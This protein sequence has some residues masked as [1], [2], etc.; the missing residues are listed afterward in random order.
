MDS[1]TAATLGKYEIVSELG[2]GGMGVV[3]RARDPIIGRFVAVKTLTS[4]LLSSPESLKR[5]YREAQAA[6]KLQHPNIVTI[7]DLGETAG[8]P[9]IA[10]EFVEGES[11]REAIVRQDP[12]PLPQKLK[13]IKQFC[14]GLG[15]AHRHGLVHR[16]VKPANILIRK[17]G[18]VKV[19]DFGIVHVE[20]TTITKSG[21]FMGTVYY[22][23][24]EQIN[25]ANVD[26]RSD[27]F[28]VG[29]VIYEFLAYLRPFDSSTMAGVINLI[30]NR[31][32]VP[33]GELVPGIPPALEG[34]VNRC[35]Q[36]DPENR[37]QSLEDLVFELDPLASALQHDRA[38]ELVSQAPELIARR[39]LAQARE[40]LHDALMLESNHPV[41]KNLLSHVDS[42][43][44]RL[45][46][47]TRLGAFVNEGWT[48]LERREYE[49]AVKSFEEAVKVD[50]QDAQAQVLLADAREKLAQANEVHQALA[51]AKTAYRG[52]DLTRAEVTLHHVLE[53]DATN[54][55]AQ[56]ILDRIRQERIER[57]RSFQ[58]REGLWE[59][60]G[61]LERG[62]YEEAL[63]RLAAL[64]RHF[65]NEVQ[66]EPI[67][68]EARQKSEELDRGIRAV[69]DCLK[70]GRFQEG[71]EQAGVLC[72]RFP[73]RPEVGELYESAQIQL[74]L[75]ERRRGLDDQ[76]H[77]IEELISGRDFAQ[78]VAE[79]ER[80]RE[81]FPESVELDRLAIL[82]RSQKQ[83][84]DLQRQVE[85]SCERV[86]A[87]LAAGRYDEAAAEADRELTRF[88]GSADLLQ[89]LVSARRS[90]F[91]AVHQAARG[92]VVQPPEQPSE[93][94]AVEGSSSATQ[95]LWAHDIPLV[96]PPPEGSQGQTVP[97]QDSPEPS[98]PTVARAVPAPEAGSSAEK[99][100]ALP[101]AP[102]RSNRKGLWTAA[103]A[104]AGLLV[105]AVSAVVVRRRIHRPP[106][107]PPPVA[108]FPVRVSTSPAGAQVSIDGQDQGASPVD[109]KLAAGTHKVRATFDGYQ[110]AETS[111]T[112]GPGSPADVSLSLP[113]LDTS[114]RVFTDFESGEVLLEGKSQGKLQDGQF[115]LEH[116]DP[117]KHDMG[118][119]SDGQTANVEFEAAPGTA[120]S[121]AAPVKAQNFGVIAVSNLGEHARVVASKASLKIGL[122]G[123]PAQEVGANG[124]EWD[125]LASGSHELLIDNGSGQ[126][127]KTIDVGAAPTLT[128]ML[129]SNRDVG[130]LTVLVSEDGA[131]VTIDG[132]AQKRL[133]ARGA[134]RI[135]N[136]KPKQYL[137][138]VEKDGFQKEPAQAAQVE[139]GQEASLT[140][141]LRP[142]ERFGALA[143][144]EALAGSEVIMDGNLIG[145]VA[146]DGTFSASKVAP[147]DHTLELRKAGYLPKQLH[148]R[149]TAR[150]TLILAGND[151]SLKQGTGI[152]LIN[153]S[154]PAQSL[155]IR[156]SDQA[157]TKP[158]NPGRNELAAGTY[159]VVARWPSGLE[160]SGKVQVQPGATETIQL[161]LERVGMNGWNPKDWRAD[162]TWHVHSGKGVVLFNP[163][164]T[165][166]TFVFTAE[167]RGGNSLAWV[168]DYTD[169]DDYV[170]CELSSK[171]FVR[172]E[173]AR[174][175]TRELQRSPNR[176]GRTAASSLRI[177]ITS[178]R[179]VQQLYDGKQ[180]VPLDDWKDPS[181]N[182]SAGKFGFLL[183]GTS[184][185]LM[186]SNFSFSPE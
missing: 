24:P 102:V 32:P 16:D 120:P 169:A 68:K 60:K 98:T 185:N 57:E 127:K 6:G 116:V 168:L 38:E 35:L 178:G 160:R 46:L 135:L 132:K 73:D 88:P 138:Q 136:L 112:V 56:A 66:I 90:Q 171:V 159:V 83:A 170:V 9:Y 143:L 106:P 25:N 22:A 2:R 36:K 17:D 78:A 33:L 8:S 28:S 115:A 122:D 128:V 148:E 142:L 53:L 147:G 177:E 176:L 40:V 23:S 144:R 82:A 84:E 87:A 174:G 1:T 4:D 48:H 86:R 42:E 151:V 47:S 139:K 105:V 140:F 179:I 152:L 34:I 103:L 163:T 162:G 114:V 5:F 119:S 153:V 167:A 3:Y 96:T 44:K 41:A 158:I 39:D 125:N 69:K 110:P 20:S 157:Q 54:S 129:T 50:S 180:F 30:L 111:A 183:A 67:L 92:P 63:E 18:T 166:G 79:C 62:R 19:V 175:V 64:Q 70:A 118:I 124:V 27:I 85:E 184:E 49:A 107:P 26:S 37:F 182:F 130:S 52:G 91:E 95:L 15:Y 164:P 10:M 31:D 72:A 89:L 21:T 71:C 161:S 61:L 104:A 149:L 108:L 76:L 77:K 117:G 43:I 181:R 55:E 13:I 65:P 186:L 113:A 146:A 75:A 155:T 126:Q 7:F 97:A 93:Q 74:N 172:K 150:Q 101:A 134:L 100:A 11:L 154:P 133:T 51:S 94:P 45:E 29:V 131:R 123:Q 58:L 156:Q 12:M 59:A 80:S 99:I 121:V 173:V 141:K 81:T 14:Q 109:L 145:T 137:V 165:A